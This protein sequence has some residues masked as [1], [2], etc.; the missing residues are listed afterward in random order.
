[1]RYRSF[2]A[3]LDAWLR[4]VLFS[5][6]GVVIG[7]VL[8]LAM[9]VL[10]FH[11]ERQMALAANQW[12]AT[13][14]AIRCLALAAMVAGFGLLTG[15]LRVVAGVVPVFASI[16][17]FGTAILA[18]SSGLTLAT[19]V[20]ALAWALHSPLA[21]LA[22]LAGGFVTVTIFVNLS[23]LVGVRIAN[24]RE[25]AAARLRPPEV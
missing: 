6:A 9:A 22:I 5:F 17:R 21:S 8:I 25:E 23:I 11:N 15:P 1:L 13:A 20:I 16:V 18:I 19:L 10:V 2:N 3:R 12:D 7:A 4:R 24:A 14:W